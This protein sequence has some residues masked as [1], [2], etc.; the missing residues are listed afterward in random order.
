MNV[1]GSV[2][3]PVF[4]TWRGSHS[5]GLARC[6]QCWVS[7]T[8]SNSLFS[9]ALGVGR[10]RVWTAIE[11]LTVQ[12]LWRQV[13]PYS[14]GEVFRVSYKQGFLSFLFLTRL[15]PRIMCED[16]V[17]WDHLCPFGGQRPVS[18]SFTMALHLRFWVRV[19]HRTWSSVIKWDWPASSPGML[20]SPSTRTMGTG[21]HTQTSYWKVGS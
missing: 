4:G 1:C 7:W 9:T 2:S 5:R 11:S 6:W 10:A 8:T 12:T 15:P 3:F 21:W 13:L 17:P 19:S 18:G 16:E 20:L 14:S